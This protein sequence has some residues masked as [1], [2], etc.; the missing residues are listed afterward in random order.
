MRFE[1]EHV[2]TIRK[3][4]KKNCYA[5][6]HLCVRFNA[7]VYDEI[8]KN[9]NYKNKNYKNKKNVRNLSI[10]YMNNVVK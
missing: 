3:K 6:V 2:F 10:D 1:T 4:K 5:C 9:K 7:C 8:K